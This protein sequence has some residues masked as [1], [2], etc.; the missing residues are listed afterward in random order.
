[1][2]RFIRMKSDGT[3]IAEVFMT[4]AAAWRRCVPDIQQHYHV[5][6]YDA[7]AAA[8]AAAAAGELVLVAWDDSPHL[9]DGHIYTANWI[10][11][12]NPNLNGLFP[13][14]AMPHL[15]ADH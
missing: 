5:M 2:Y 11:R 6:M 10:Q 4:F 12:F 9:L 13:A 3:L 7:A 1:M 14:L 15:H 8:L